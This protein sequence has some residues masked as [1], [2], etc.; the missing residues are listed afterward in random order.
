MTM[1]STI[2]EFVWPR[3]A[4]ADCINGMVVRD[5]RGC[6]LDQAQRLNFYPAIA[7]PAVAWKL[8]GDWHRIDHPDQMEQP[9]T[10]ATGRAKIVFG[11]PRLG[12]TIIWNPGEFYYIGIAFLPHALSAMTGLDVSAFTERV[13]AAEEAL[14][15]PMLEAC[16]NFFDTVPR[17]GPERSFSVLQEKIEIMWAAVRPA[18]TRSFTAD[19]ITGLV[20]R[21]ATTGSGRSTRQ[22]ARR[23]KSWAG[24]G[25]R[26]LEGLSHVWQYL[27]FKNVLDEV[28]RKDDVDW[29][30]LAATLGFSDQAH[31]IRRIKQYTGFTPK[32][33]SERI[34]YDEAFWY[35]RLVAHAGD[36]YLE[37][38]KGQ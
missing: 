20:H 5:T 14:P 2:S 33:L 17:E 6:A 3:A 9:W 21:A 35:Y 18:G 11:G 24:V 32:Q 30:G 23:F 26:D 34:R 16:R 25:Q 4:L 15:R 8:A 31:M 7:N 22:I 12:P 27:L 19:Y 28:M 29:A 10:G 1:T 38:S 37:L 13:V 36:E